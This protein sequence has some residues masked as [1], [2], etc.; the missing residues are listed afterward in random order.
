MPG[1]VPVPSDRLDDVSALTLPPAAS[2]PP[3][4]GVPWLASAVPVVGALGFWALTGSAFAL[5]FAV[6]GPVIAVAGVL[7][8]ARGARRERRDAAARAAEARERVAERIAAHHADERAAWTAQHPDAGGFAH[9]PEQIWRP[10]PGR[11]DRIV[12]GSG[13]VASALRVAGGQDDAADGELVRAARRVPDAPV[14]A[15]L[16]GGVAVVGPPVVARAVARAL[17]LQAACAMPPGALEVRCSTDAEEWVAALPHAARPGAFR[18]GWA[19]AGGTVPDADALLLE[20]GPGEALPPGCASVL[21]L[22]S[23]GRGRAHLDGVGYDVGV[24]AVGR[25]QAAVIAAELAGRAD[26]TGE[27]RGAIALAQLRPPARQRSRDALPVELALAAGEPFAVDLVADGPHAVVTGTTGAG[28]SELLVSWVLALCARYTTA[29]VA[30]LLVDFK[31]GTAFE[32]LRAV[33]HVT[34]VVT[35]LDGGG[36]RRAIESL[37]AEVRT[38]ETALA[39]AGAREIAAID[40]PRL[41]VVVDEFAALRDTHPDLDALF[42]DL[43]ARGR[44]LGIHLVLGTQRAAGVLRDGVLA[45]SGLRMSLRVADPHDSRAVIGVPDAAEL[46]GDPDARG[47]ALIRRAADT[48]PTRVRIARSGADDVRAAA[49]DAGA[50]PRAPWLPPLPLAID[51]DSLPCGEPG[52]VI[53]GLAD[54]PERQRQLAVALSS[55]DRGL[56]VVGGAGAGKTTLLETAA[57]QASR[58]LFVGPDPE[59]AWD[60]LCAAVMQPLP[61]GAL[62]VIDDLD[63]LTLRLPEEYARAAA[64]AV[65]QLVRDAGARRLRVVAAAQ[66]VTGIAGRVADL[67][68]RRMLLPIPGRA[69]WVAAGGAPAQHEL[70]SSPGRGVL[71][72]RVVQVAVARGLDRREAAAVV[73][74]WHPPVGVSAAVLPR[75]AREALALWERT[76]VRVRSVVD[77]DG[78]I[79]GGDLPTVIVG[80]GEQ[81]LSRP[82]LLERIRDAHELIVDAACGRDLRALTGER[83]L[84]PFLAAVPGRAWSYAPDRPPRRVALLPS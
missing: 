80:D 74:L 58:C 18:L 24:E 77:D 52:S 46:P 64:A 14:L 13:D 66:R 69:E 76:G 28:K 6:L 22:S 34:G 30:F 49:T 67:F 54:E 40:M 47:L 27:E 81:W 73:G 2:A 9:R 16:S 32:P 61:A 53:L 44:A 62:V 19:R 10:V 38:R 72:G 25:E 55:A 29:D 39:E 12:I 1:F 31:G 36:A 60:A 51:L 26:E 33:P 7:D 70:A 43:A 15:T 59:Q 37:R 84:P 42:G 82:R 3:R 20:V 56:L 83:D 8:G 78:S 68:P 23:L 4:P 17:L 57:A 48:R 75:H 5:W 11:A 35:D 63:A 79:G 41:V 45:N 50:P 65:E 21:E 71:D